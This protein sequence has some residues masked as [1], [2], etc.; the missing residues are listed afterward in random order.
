MKWTERNMRAFL[1]GLSLRG[2]HGL[3]VVE[4]L[5]VALHLSIFDLLV[6]PKRPILFVADSRRHVWNLGS[7]M[8][9]TFIVTFWCR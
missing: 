5:L 9:G 6:G 8:D 2:C 3:C 7:S 1:F 4:N